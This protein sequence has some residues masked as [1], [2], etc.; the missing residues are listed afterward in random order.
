MANLTH[1]LHP[2]PA[3]LARYVLQLWTLRGGL[4]PGQELRDS[5]VA[6]SCPGLLEG[7]GGVRETIGISY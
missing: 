3:P 5:P 7:G 2:V 6:D 4:A 1:L